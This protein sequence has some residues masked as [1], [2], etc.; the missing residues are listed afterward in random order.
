MRAWYFQLNCLL[1]FML[2]LPTQSIAQSNRAG[3][4]NYILGHTTPDSLNP[5]QFTEQDQPLVK[6]TLTLTCHHVRTFIAARAD[7]AGIPVA[8][9]VLAFYDNRLFKLSCDENDSLSRAV[10]KPF[11]PGVRKPVRYVRMCTQDADKRMSI[12][13]DA[14]LGED[15][16]AFAVYRQGYTAECQPVKKAT[17]LLWSQK[18]ASLSS[19]CDLH[20]SDPLVEEYSNA[21]LRK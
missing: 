11:G 6:G 3:L 21:Q 14:W 2:L 4:G 15:T 20:P 16:I 7:I 17:L 13:G 8:N 18:V 19:E 12:W 5:T 1:V 10:I 9:L